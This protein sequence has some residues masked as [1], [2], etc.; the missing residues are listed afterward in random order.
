MLSLQ[1]VLHQRGE[2]QLGKQ[3]AGGG[4]IGLLRAHRLRLELD[5]NVRS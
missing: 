5:G 2:F 1:E 4:R 3:R